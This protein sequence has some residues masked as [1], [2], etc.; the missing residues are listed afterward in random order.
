MQRANLRSEDPPEV[1]S[2]IDR[3]RQRH[4]HAVFVPVKAL[5]CLLFCPL[6]LKIITFTNQEK[7]NAHGMMR[8]AILCVELMVIWLIY[9]WFGF[10]TTYDMP[11]WM[12]T[13][14]VIIVDRLTNL[15]TDFANRRRIR[16]S[17]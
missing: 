3:Q 6:M 12:T 5:F 2:D 1:R 15:I 13:F 16:L 10:V 9:F 11:L 8:L 17:Q 7:G 4:K 14:M